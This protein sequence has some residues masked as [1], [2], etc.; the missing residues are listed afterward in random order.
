MMHAQVEQNDQW[1]YLFG[2]LMNHSSGSPGTELL[3]VILASWACGE[4]ALPQ[5]LGLSQDSY[6]RMLNT[7][8]NGYAINDYVG[9]KAMPEAERLDEHDDVLK[10]ML[11]NVSG[12]AEC[13]SWFAEI[14]TAGC[15][16]QDHLW[17]DLGLRNRKDLSQLMTL[18]FP[19]LAA[20]NDKDMKWKKFI[21]KQLCNAE[22]IYTCRAP[23]CEVCTDYNVCF[24]P[25]E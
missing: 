4:G 25:E 11:Q 3:A 7:C 2:E 1:Q 18:N 5:Y 19:T 12:M 8:F 23:S 14:V 6:Q 9:D 24:G 16:G 21:Y 17:Q 10:L 20:R 15:Q 22:G 13:S